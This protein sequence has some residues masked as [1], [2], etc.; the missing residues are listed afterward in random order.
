MASGDA[1][2]FLRDRVAAC[3]Q[4]P[5]DDRAACPP[6]T[7]DADVVFWA[8]GPQ[9]RRVHGSVAVNVAPFRPSF[10]AS[11]LREMAHGSRA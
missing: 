3:E 10:D 4:S 2:C 6:A 8:R 11:S 7:S 5:V 9:Q 1:S